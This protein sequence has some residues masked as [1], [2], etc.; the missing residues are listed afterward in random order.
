MDAVLMAL[1]ETKALMGSYVNVKKCDEAV[2]KV[3]Q[4]KMELSNISQLLNTR[5][6]LPEALLPFHH[7]FLVAF[8][9]KEE[10]YF[11]SLTE[12]IR[13]LRRIL[14]TNAKDAKRIEIQS[15][16]DKSTR[17]VN[18]LITDYLS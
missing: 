7:A 1:K 9:F 10:I 16:I 2:K 12:K 15:E 5:G 3:Q 13:H 6:R 18:T 17:T 8:G 4:M 14:R 11:S